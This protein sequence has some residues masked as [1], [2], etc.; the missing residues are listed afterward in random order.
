MV[1][2]RKTEERDIEEIKKI[3]ANAF[4][5]A[6]E[7]MNCIKGFREYVM[8]ATNQGYAY[9]IED[10]GVCCAVILAYEKPDIIYGKNLYIE[11]LSVLPE[12][13]K[14]GYSKIL[15]NQ[16]IKDAKQKDIRQITVATQ[17]FKEAYQIYLK[18]GFKD[19][20]MDRRYMYKDLK[21]DPE[22]L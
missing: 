13:Q 8:F 10:D 14:K 1:N 21:K 3:Y 12:Y 22:L 15:I 6:L 18:Y 5:Y 16:I 9:I 19:A 20:E 7:T 17:C 4:G 2:I 11:L